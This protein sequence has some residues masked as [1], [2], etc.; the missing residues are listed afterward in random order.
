MR[1]Q[2]IEH[3][4]VIV[5]VTNLRDEFRKSPQ[6]RSCWEISYHIRVGIERFLSSRTLSFHQSKPRGESPW[7]LRRTISC[8]ISATA[9]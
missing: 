9:S 8:W 5:M 3:T 7:D 6:K 1:I 4:Y 2:R